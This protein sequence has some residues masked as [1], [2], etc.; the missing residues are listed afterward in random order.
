MK[1]Y[2]CVHARY[3]VGAAYKSWP[4]HGAPYGQCSKDPARA[5]YLQRVSMVMIEIRRRGERRG[6]RWNHP[7]IECTSAPAFSFRLA[8]R[9]NFKNAGKK[10]RAIICPPLPSLS[11]NFVDVLLS[12]FIAFPKFHTSIICTQNF[13]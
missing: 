8:P 7:D 3:S 10:C 13:L 9:R 4:C 1:S 2:G 11:Q 6:R 5:W 12:R